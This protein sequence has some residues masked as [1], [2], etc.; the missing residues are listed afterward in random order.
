MTS[1][2]NV[3]TT[4]PSTVLIAIWSYLLS[5][6]LNH[7]LAYFPIPPRK[8]W[9]YQVGLIICLVYSCTSNTYDTAWHIVCPVSDFSEWM[10]AQSPLNSHNEWILIND[11]HIADIVT[12]KNI[13]SAV[14]EVWA[15]NTITHKVWAIS[16]GKESI[17]QTVWVRNLPRKSSP[18]KQTSILISMHPL[19][20]RKRIWWHANAVEQ[21]FVGATHPIPP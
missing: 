6:P 13:L 7:S 17:T 11:R 9:V 21:R 10:R 19:P 4:S 2:N 5:C 16:Y 20:Q 18:W 3:I 12:N 8:I 1:T 15:K 14:R